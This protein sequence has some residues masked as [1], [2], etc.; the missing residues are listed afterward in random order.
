MYRGKETPHFYAMIQEGAGGVAQPL[1]FRI[2]ARSIPQW[3]TI[4]S[5]I[6]KDFI[7]PAERDQTVFRYLRIEKFRSLLDKRAVWF[8]NLQKLQDEFEG[9]PPIPILSRM[10]AKD[11]EMKEWFP[12]EMRR[13]QFDTMTERQ[14]ADSKA[15]TAVNC[16]HLSETESSRMWKEYAGPDGV[17]VCST[18]KALS[19]AFDRCGQEPFPQL[20][21]VKY[22]DFSTY[23]RL[24]IH[25]LHRD[26]NLDFLKD[27]RFQHEQEV[28]IA[29][30]N[31]WQPQAGGI[32]WPARLETM[33]HQVVL[34]PGADAADREGIQALL[35]A[36]SLRV[37]VVNSALA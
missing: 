10:K 30:L 31:L 28:R 32:L 21:L 34:P 12:D 2:I 20:G 29:T 13:V 16:W 1:I 3:I 24:E 36:R 8:C 35:D 26:F 11:M 19:E 14:I 18:V 23:D 4:V 6:I 37:P 17:A 9:V 5:I 7:S 33:I 22:V 25:E 27:Q 15:L